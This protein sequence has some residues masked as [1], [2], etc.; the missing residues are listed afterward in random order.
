MHLGRF[1]TR[2]E[3]NLSILEFLKFLKLNYSLCGYLV[4]LVVHNSGW[5][6]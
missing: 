2:S 1:W 4:K 5:L 3:F 6:L